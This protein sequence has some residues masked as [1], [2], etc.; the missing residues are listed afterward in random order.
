MAVKPAQGKKKGKTA[1][2]F[3]AAAKDSTKAAKGIERSDPEGTVDSLDT[4]R[5]ST[6]DDKPREPRH[7]SRLITCEDQLDTKIELK[8]GQPLPILYSGSF[9]VAPI[10]GT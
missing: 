3:H 2:N 4:R 9:Q 1:T 10:L 8:P 6:V 5:N 7:E